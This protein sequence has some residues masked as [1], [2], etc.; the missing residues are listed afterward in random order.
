VLA[1][2]AGEFRRLAHQVP[3]FE[4]ARDLQK[5]VGAFRTAIQIGLPEGGHHGIG[6]LLARLQF[7]HFIQP[8]WVAITQLPE[9]A[10]SGLGLREA[11]QAL[12]E[13]AAAGV[14][15]HAIGPNF[16]GG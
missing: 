15:V 5:Q 11:H 3:A 10:V 12:F 13:R 9:C 4:L 2:E 7:G 8:A 14:E 1:G 6:L 16:D